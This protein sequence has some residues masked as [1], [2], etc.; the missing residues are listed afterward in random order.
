M[1]EVL[2]R[3]S[4]RDKVAQIDSLTVGA[5]VSKPIKTNQYELIVKWMFGDADTYETDVFHVM[6]H[7]EELLIGF[8]NFLLRCMAAY[9]GGM[10]GSS[11]F[12]HVEGFTTYVVNYD[13]DEDDPD[14]QDESTIF[15]EEGWPH[16]EYAGVGSPDTVSLCFYD[17]NGIKH[18]VEMN[19]IK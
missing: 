2:Y 19:E 8:I 11:D 12:Q 9:P 18:K 7:D 13:I 1:T 10:G 4:H 6:K 3:R 14:A 15:L 16:Q 17:E 5:K